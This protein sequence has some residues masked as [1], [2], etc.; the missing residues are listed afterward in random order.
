MGLS[1]VESLKILT[2]S[3][4]L[5]D[6]EGK[7]K[8]VIDTIYNINKGCFVEKKKYIIEIIVRFKIKE[9]KRNKL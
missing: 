3:L 5:V 7:K 6:I 2:F 1:L 4:C 9:N 8:R